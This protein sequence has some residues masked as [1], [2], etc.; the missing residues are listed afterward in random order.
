MPGIVLR[1]DASLRLF[2]LYSSARNMSMSIFPT[3]LVYL[4]RSQSGRLVRALL[5]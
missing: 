1:R 2:F 3:N 4:R 5:V